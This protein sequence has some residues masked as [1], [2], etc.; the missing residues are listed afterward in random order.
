MYNTSRFALMGLALFGAC[1]AD[2][3]EPIEIDFHTAALQQ[4]PVVS[5]VAAEAV[6]L[7][8]EL[9]ARL[10]ARG[11]TTAELQAAIDAGDE[12]LMRELFGFTDQELEAVHGRLLAVAVG[13][14]AAPGDRGVSPELSCDGTWAPCFVGAAWGASQLAATPWLAIAIYAV[15][16]GAC[17]W[18][19]CNRRE[20]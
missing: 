5:D 17:A 19:A 9:A 7:Y 14:A 12:E 16:A 20:P 4:D 1:I 3:G 15:S 11:V 13:T 8:Q 10:D 2:G 18:Q 6:A